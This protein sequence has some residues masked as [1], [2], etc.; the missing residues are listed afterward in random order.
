[1]ILFTHGFVP[2]IND[3]LFAPVP[4]LDI[5]STPC[6]YTCIHVLHMD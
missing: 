4:Y 3:A 1:M 6:I 2:M 5:C